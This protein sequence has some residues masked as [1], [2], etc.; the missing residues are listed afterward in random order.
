MRGPDFVGVGAPR[1]GTS[2]LYEV[3]SAHEA[4]WL[5]PVKELHYFDEPG[6]NKR[7]F[8]YLRTRLIS[9]LWVR[10]PL[11]RFDI[12]YFL[13]RRSDDWY[14]KLFE[15][16]R[17]RGLITGEIT[18]A[19]SVIGTEALQRLKTVNPD[20][21]LIFIMR[22]PIM[23][24]WSAVMKMQRNRG[25]AG[26]P[27]G[28]EAIEYARSEGVWRRSSYLE[29][30]ERFERVFPPRQIFYG[31]FDQLSQDP[32]AFVTSVLSFIGA[33]SGDVRHLLPATPVNIAAGGRQPP[34]EFVRAVAAACLPWVDKLC[35]RFEGPPHRWRAQYQAL[36]AGAA[37]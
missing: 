24:S 36:L 20:V 3:L 10:R 29:N 22:D 6:G 11:S 21:K 14:C 37:A 23:R 28:V 5:P 26:V 8:S 16:A 18:P 34:P 2:W 19:Y 1:S 9:G 13:G 15:P 17:K 35:Q 12:R 30:I 33:P 31:F 4:L 27:S 7:Y 32:E 25:L